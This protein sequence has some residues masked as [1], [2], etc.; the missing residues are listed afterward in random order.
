[1]PSAMRAA[2]VAAAVRYRLHWFY[3]LRSIPRS[4]NG[5]TAAFGAVNRGSNPCRGAKLLNRVLNRDSPSVFY[6]FHGSSGAGFRMVRT[7]LFATPHS[8]NR[9]SRIRLG[10]A[11]AAL[12]GI[13]AKQLGRSACQAQHLNCVVDGQWSG[14]LHVSDLREYRV[15]L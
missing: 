1:M 12:E 2:S 3:S 4:S 8:A 9:P 15:L 6:N 7:V 13:A 10:V 11:D 14:T 5:R